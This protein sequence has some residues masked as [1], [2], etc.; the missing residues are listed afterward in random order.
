M[1]ETQTM[2]SQPK[3]ELYLPKSMQNIKTVTTA[4]G[5][6]AICMNGILR[7]L[8]FLLLS[9]NEAMSGSVTAS[10]TRLKAVIKPITVKNPPIA[11]PGMMYWTAP[12]AT[13]VLTGKK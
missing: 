8:G 1:T 9:D 5:I 12:F 3:L 11:R 6:A 2:L 7:P 10:K 4:N 13:S